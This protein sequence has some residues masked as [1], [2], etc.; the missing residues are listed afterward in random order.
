MIKAGFQAGLLPD[1][2][3][4]LTPVE[5][6]LAIEARVE[7]QEQEWKRTAWATA[8]I[9]NATGRLKRPITL[10]RL[11]P[12]LY[13]KSKARRYTDEEWEEQKRQLEELAKKFP[14]PNKLRRPQ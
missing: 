11:L 9:M 3:W 8:H 10:Q 13:G 7:M 12:G 1:E 2:L 6:Q 14:D 4:S 5:A